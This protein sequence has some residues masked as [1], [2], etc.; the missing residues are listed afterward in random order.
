MTVLEHATSQLSLSMSEMEDKVYTLMESLESRIDKATDKVKETEV[1]LARAALAR[2]ATA[3]TSSIANNPPPP[4]AG[5]RDAAQEAGSNSSHTA[6][7]QARQILRGG[8]VDRALGTVLKTGR[9]KDVMTLA[10]ETGPVIRH[11]RPSTLNKVLTILIAHVPLDGTP[12]ASIE[13]CLDW[14]EAAADAG[15]GRLDLAVIDAACSS[16]ESLASSR[17]SSGTRSARLYGRL[18]PFLMED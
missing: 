6:L 14:L 4:R 12:H 1:V 2:A 10:E 5:P 13:L 17:T 18:V 16:L 3:R 8:Q 7:S 15:P 11:L 9:D